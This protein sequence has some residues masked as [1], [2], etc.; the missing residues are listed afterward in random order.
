MGGIDAHIGMFGTNAFTEGKLS[1]N[2]GTSFCILGNI[3]DSSK[4][5]NSFW[6]P[7]KNAVCDGMGCIEGGQSS[8]AGLVNWF[9]RNFHIDRTCEIDVYVYLAEALKETEPGA[10]GLIMLDHFQGNRTPY[11]DPFS[12]GAFYGLTMQHS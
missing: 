7:Y 2:M 10:G 6:G 1:V 8:A 4:K 5:L 12:K 9:V 11:K 3:N